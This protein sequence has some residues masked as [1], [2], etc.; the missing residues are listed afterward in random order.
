MIKRTIEIEITPEEAAIV[1]ANMP[2]DEQARFFNA[3]A[4][5]AL[6]WDDAHSLAGFCMQMEYM[7]SARGMLT[8]LTP[9]GRRVMEIIGEYA[10][11]NEEA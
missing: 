11:P 4:E 8:K 3:L 1:F 10:R 5:D 6:T 7:R 2:S 9:N